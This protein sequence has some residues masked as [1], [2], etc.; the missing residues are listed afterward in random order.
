MAGNR[1][2][3]TRVQLKYDTFENWMNNDPVLLAG[4]IAIA[5]VDTTNG[6]VSN[7]NFQNLPNVVLKVGDGVTEYSKLKFVSGLAADVYEWAKADKK[8]SYTANEIQGLTEYVQNISDVDTN[9]EYQLVVVDAETYKYKLQK[10]VYANNAWG[11]WT[12]TETLD[13]SAIDTRLDSVEAAVAALGGASGG[14]QTAIKVAIEA[15]DS[16]KDQAAGDDGLALHIKLED[17]RVTEFSGSI[18]AETY[19]DYGAAKAVQ[20]A[21]T[22][23]VKDAMDAAGT[24]QAA[25][26]AAQ[27]TADQEILDRVAAIEALDYNGYVAG[28][29]EGQ[30]IS[31]VGTISEKD[32]V[33]SATKRDLVFTDAYSAST[34]PVATK[35]YVDDEV[36]KVVTDVTNAM[37]FE[38][39]VEGDTFA[40]AVAKRKD[41]EAGDIVIYGT[42]EHVYDGEKWYELGNETMAGTLIA[43]IDSDNYNDIVGEVKTANPAKTITRIV[44]EDGFITSVESAEIVIDSDHVNVGD[45]TLT[46]KLSTMESNNST[47]H[48]NMQL[49]ID[50]NEAAIALLNGND[51]QIGSVANSVKVAIEALDAVVSQTAGADG[52]ALSITEVDGVIT[53]ISGS[54]AANTYDAAGAAKAVQGATTKTVAEVE[55][56]ANAA[57]AAADKEILD[58][59][60]AIEALDGSATASSADNGTVNVLTS[61]VETDGRI[62]MG[63]EVNLSKAA[64]T[65]LVSDLLQAENTYIVFNCGSSTVNI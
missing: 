64:Q 41:W 63:A 24:A 51:T 44:Q 22:S 39:V 9:T 17:G 14:I 13:L 45:V 58:R 33:V 49:E 65:G 50:A 37:H 32:G 11:E 52:L 3:Q 55:A 56:L 54:I 42:I 8:P 27:R 20:G 25:A 19:D 57:Q 53:S 30:T 62:S 1:T 46:S 47:A 40:E 18:A 7:P 6:T 60:A 26:E 29:A 5:T 38:G 21:T 35:K 28:E 34:N 48:S 12:D 59:V 43:A 2:F 10:R 23:T 16:E 15:L 31:F 4:E 36:L 61:V